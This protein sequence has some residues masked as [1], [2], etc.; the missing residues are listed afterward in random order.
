MTMTNAITPNRVLIFEPELNYLLSA[1]S[2]YG[3]EGSMLTPGW[4]RVDQGRI[5]GLGSGPAS[6]RPGET[7]LDLGGLW[8]GPGL[9]DAHVHLDLWAG[10]GPDPGLRTKVRK[11]ADWGLAGVRDGGD[12][13]C[14]VLAA[15]A[16][17]EEFL[18]LAASG[19]ALYSPGRYGGFLGRPIKN[20]QDMALAVKE[21]AA[22]GVD[23]IKIL[24]SGPVS[25]KTFGQVGP[26]QF[27]EEDLKALVDLAGEQGLPVMAHANGPQ[28]TLMCLRAGVASLEH[29][30]FM[31]S[32][33][34]ALLAESG[35]AWV[36]TVAPLAALAETET[37]PDIK[38]RLEKTIVHQLGQLAEARE[39][40]VRTVLGSDAGSPGNEPGP[41]LFREMKLWL[42]AGYEANEILRTGTAESADLLWPNQNR[43][44]LTIG[45]PARLIGL[46][47]DLSSPPAFMGR[48]AAAVSGAFV[49]P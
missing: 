9:I 44:R 4:I 11:A 49:L 16:V 14:S 2:V 30:Y 25:L 46:S 33:T 35:I 45:A 32:E 15:R 39:T 27:C 24:A 19:S 20:T 47:R 48:P 5:S 29:G 18:A 26:P 37:D 3:H 6:A 12:K 1:A 10:S 17:V 42:E 38:Y 21:M 8:L 7:A 34:M 41:G 13:T 22:V 23:Q 31:G 36:P 43:G 28:A 40:G